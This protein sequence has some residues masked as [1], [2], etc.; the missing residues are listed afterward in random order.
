MEKKPTRR[1]SWTAVLLLVALLSTGSFFLARF[2]VEMRQPVLRNS[3]TLTAKPGQNI[4]PLGSGLIYYDDVALHALNDRG[5]QIWTH[6]P[7]AGADFSV[8]LGGVAAWSGTQLSLLTADRGE[9]LYSGNLED[10]VLS[11]YLGTSYAAAQ[12]GEEHNSSIVLMETGGRQVETIDLPN[13]TVLDFGFFSGGSLFWVMSLNTEGTV[14]ICTI[15]T[16]RPGK[17]LA[18]TVTDVDQILY[19]VMFQS[20]QIRAVG[21]TYLRTY[22]YQGT[23]I[24]DKRKLVYGWYLMGV[25]KDVDN[26]LMAFVPSSQ[27]GGVANVSDVRLIRGDSDQ[28]IRLPVP[29]FKLFTKNDTL[30]AFSNNYVLV[31]RLG[32]SKP[33]AYRL[34]MYIENVVGVVDGNAAIVSSGDVTYLVPLP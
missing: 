15:T 2:I 22:N 32:E 11:A 4:K 23:E 34:P 28:T 25:E 12:I 8:G 16:Y 3:I 27:T 9:A 17:I 26:P 24:A 19:K 31:C 6:A 20:T 5:Q 1:L 7:G 14:P 30:Y 21:T 13:Q 33:T 29:C 18:G 10:V